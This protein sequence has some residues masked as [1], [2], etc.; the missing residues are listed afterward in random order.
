MSEKHTHWKKLTNPD[1]LGAYSFNPGEEKILRIKSVSQE[2]VVGTDGKK[3]QCTVAH[4][5][6]GEKPMIL[7]RTNCKAISKIYNT[8]Y[9]ED[10]TG[11]RVTIYVAQVKAFGE[12]VDALRIRPKKPPEE[13]EFKCECCER[14]IES[15]RGNSPEWLA[16]YTKNEYGKA[17][18]ADC[19]TKAKAEKDRVHNDD[20]EEI[21]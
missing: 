3:E 17:L 14:K 10:W 1:Y 4:F 2:L 20:I 6:G 12:V 9:I 7:N 8:P 16:N 5:D 19:A 11:K 21:E 13:R 18:C 15:F